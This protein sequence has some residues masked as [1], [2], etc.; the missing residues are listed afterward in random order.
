MPQCANLKYAPGLCVTRGRRL[1]VCAV[2]PFPSP[3]D[4]G[5]HAQPRG[6]LATLAAFAPWHR[7]A[8][9]GP[10]WD[11]HEPEH[12]GRGHCQWHS[13][14]L[15]GPR[16]AR[17]RRPGCPWSE[18]TGAARRPHSKLGGCQCVAQRPEPSRRRA[19]GAGS[20]GRTARLRPKAATA[21]LAWAPPPLPRGS[22]DR[23][24]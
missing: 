15:A 19:L 5:C 6:H 17:R 22:R 11:I 20:A 18:S 16:R 21:S 2:T 1:L 4:G 23:A 12:P 13:R 9:P 8:R 3:G 14:K 24:G 10:A 7:D